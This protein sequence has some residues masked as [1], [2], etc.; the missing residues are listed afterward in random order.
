MPLQKAV[1]DS[2]QLF[3]ESTIDST[4]NKVRGSSK[5]ETGLINKQ[6]Y[7]YF[8]CSYFMFSDLK[9]THPESVHFS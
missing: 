3:V 4:S 5:N 6:R 1:V 7:F 2:Q 8:S 9:K